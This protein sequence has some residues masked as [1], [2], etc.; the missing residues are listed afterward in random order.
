MQYRRLYVI[1]LLSLCVAAARAQDGHGKDAAPAPVLAGIVVDCSGSQRLQLDRIITST[2]QLIDALQAN[3]RAFVIRFVDS[4]N[5]NLAQD[6]TDNKEEL[7]DAAESFFIQAGQKAIVDAVDLAARH[8]AEA[9]K[10]G[11][12]Q[13]VMV[14]ITDGEDRNSVKKITDAIASLK[15][16]RVRVFA[17]GIS[18]LPVATKLLDRLTRETGGKTFIPRTVGDLTKAVEEISTS[19]RKVTATK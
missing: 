13:R 4:Q 18:D 12:A 8:F 17:I 5:I 19:M 16:H 2:R 11:A 15:E 9:Q 3:D 10:D 7:T 6:I 1:L 14:L